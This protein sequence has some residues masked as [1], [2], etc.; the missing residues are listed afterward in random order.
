LIL[1]FKKVSPIF[2]LQSITINKIIFQLPSTLTWAITIAYLISRLPFPIYP[3]Y[4]NYNGLSIF[5]AF[6]IIPCL[7]QQSFPTALG[8]NNTNLLNAI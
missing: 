3:S 4:Y 6:I 5:K 1:A 2:T 8:I 7:L